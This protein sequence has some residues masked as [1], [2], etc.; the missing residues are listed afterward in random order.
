MLLVTSFLVN[1]QR[2]MDSE[3]DLLIIKTNKMPNPRFL[4][5]GIQN[6]QTVTTENITFSHTR[7]VRNQ[8]EN[9]KK[10]L[11]GPD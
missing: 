1:L 8:F 10:N 6:R 9:E 7:A 2:S 11:R 4:G 5:Q 3:L